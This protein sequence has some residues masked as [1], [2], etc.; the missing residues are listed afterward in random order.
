MAVRHASV[1]WV[2]VLLA[3]GLVGVGT[4]AVVWWPVWFGAGEGTATRP[5]TATVQAHAPCG[6]PQ[7]RDTVEFELDG[8]RH[9]ARLN[10]CG[11][12]A[13]EVL[14]V[15]VPTEAD[16]SG[17]LVVQLADAV[18]VTEGPGLG[19]RLTMVLLAV[20]GMAG[21]V[22]LLAL[23][24]RARRPVPAAKPGTG[25]PAT[26]PE[27]SAEPVTPGT[28]GGAE[29][30]PTEQFPAIVATPTTPDESPEEPAEQPALP[31]SV[32]VHAGG[33]TAVWSGSFP[34]APPDS[35]SPSSVSPSSSGSWDSRDG[36]G[37]GG[38][39]G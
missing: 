7:A 23:R 39:F 24:R 6:D 8:E 11:H 5:A 37:S 30:P 17:E 4:A 33:T 27:S 32:P 18:P 20:A 21:G 28:P 13:G 15:A 22:L 38:W 1:R 12:R 19:R 2:L 25:Q 16:P 26:T 34:V 9:Q 35:V 36:Q 29:E 14:Q 10:G 3:L 31:E